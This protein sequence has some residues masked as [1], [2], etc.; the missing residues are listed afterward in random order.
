[1]SASQ[2]IKN[3]RFFIIK[4]QTEK[5]KSKAKKRWKEKLFFPF[6]KKKNTTLMLAELI[7][8]KNTITVGFRKWLFGIWKNLIAKWS[9]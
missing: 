1:M 6:L 2:K 9:K 3:T 7:L 4:Q 5:K 8:A